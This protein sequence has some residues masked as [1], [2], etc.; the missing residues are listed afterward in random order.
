MLLVLLHSTNDLS[1]LVI[2]MHSDNAIT[3]LYY[4]LLH[5]CYKPT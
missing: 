3:K 4:M 5:G 2:K 1:I